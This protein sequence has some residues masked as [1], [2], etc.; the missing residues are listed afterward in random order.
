MVKMGIFI[1]FLVCQKIMQNNSVFVYGSL[2]NE[3]VLQILLKRVP[4]MKDAMLKNFQ[5]QSVAEKPYP[6][7]KPAQDH[8]V[9]G[10]LLCELS[11][12]E[13]QILDAFE[14]CHQ[15]HGAEY[16]REAVQV[17]L[18]NNEIV[19]T[20]VYVYGVPYQCNLYGSWD[21]DQFV[22]TALE[23][24]LQACKQFDSEYHQQNKL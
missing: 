19:D 23:G 14:V 4:L 11:D 8:Q 1:F 12:E 2:Q 18:G 3:Q 7:V 17:H 24:F 6:G 22:Q 16:V 20:Y 10:K 13:M 21:Y 15:E 9:A 5:R